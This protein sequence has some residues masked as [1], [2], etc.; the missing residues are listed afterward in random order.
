MLRPFG[1]EQGNFSLFVLLVF[2]A[3]YLFT[4]P[5]QYVWASGVAMAAWGAFG[6][7]RLA[8]VSFA[9]SLTKPVAGSLPARLMATLAQRENRLREEGHTRLHHADIQLW[10]GLG[11]AYALWAFINF[12]APVT[13]EAVAALQLSLNE[14]WQDLGGP[15]PEIKLGGNRDA[16]I[17]QMAFLFCAGVATFTVHS[18]SYNERYIKQG[19][20]IIV[21]LFIAGAIYAVLQGALIGAVTYID[22]LSWRGAG[23]GAATV[24]TAVLPDLKNAHSALMQRWVEQGFYGVAMVYALYLLPVWALVR[25]ML[26]AQKYAL[27]LLAFATLGVMAT[28]DALLQGSGW[29]YA[30][31]F[32]GT[33][34]V[35]LVWGHS[36]YLRPI[37]APRLDMPDRD[38]AF[39]AEYES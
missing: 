23:A 19:A 6:A 31:S 25:F 5:V 35:A 32:M 27:A 28:L 37:W 2:A 11:C 3:A 10:F 34:F 20:I 30:L 26:R 33:A 14:F 15:G 12:L 9:G 16:L 39:D 18:F 24:L 17:R 22:T 36:A 21:P 8:A 4:L 29:V 1:S 13:L 38:A 7:W